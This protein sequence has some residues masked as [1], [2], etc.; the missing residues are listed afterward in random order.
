M[1]N[2]PTGSP[3]KDSQETTVQVGMLPV[4]GWTPTLS[5][6][7]LLPH[8]CDPPGSRDP[9]QPEHLPGRALARRRQ[10]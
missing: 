3:R 2:A 9:T 7:A 8:P 1:R 6:T 10:S 4:Q 5:A